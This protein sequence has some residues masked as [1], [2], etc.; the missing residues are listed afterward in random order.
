MLRRTEYDN[1]IPP[2]GAHLTTG[3]YKGNR[4][5]QREQECG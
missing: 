5:L 2:R 4:I 3:K 1:H